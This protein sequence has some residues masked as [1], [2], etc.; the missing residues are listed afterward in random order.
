MNKTGTI[1]EL[2][3]NRATIMTNECRYV[4][5]KRR[6]KM[7]VGQQVVFFES[8]LIKPRM[9]VFK[10]AGIAVSIAVGFLLIFLSYF[11]LIENRNIY[12]FVN[13]DI[14]PSVEIAIDQGK[15]VLWAKP[16]NEDGK[17]LLSSLKL[18]GESLE[19]A[20]KDILEQ[21]KKNGVIKV[22]NGKYIL[23]SASLNPENAQNKT[24]K[25]E[26]EAKLDSY[27]NSFKDASEEELIW[28]VIHTTPEDRKQA[29]N[30][31]ISSGKYYIY[32]KLIENSRGLS[33]EEVRRSS[34]SGL[35]DKLKADSGTG[36]F[37]DEMPAANHE[38]RQEPVKEAD[39]KD[40]CE[41]DILSNKQEEALVFTGEAKKDTDST[42][43]FKVNPDYSHP[44]PDRVESTATESTPAPP[45]QTP[46]KL[47]EKFTKENTPQGT[48]EIWKADVQYRVGD[49]VNYEGKEFRC[50][51]AHKS[52][53]DWLTPKV[54]ALWQQQV[55]E[56]AAN[57]WQAGISFKS[58]SLVLYQGIKYKCLQSHTS[59]TGWE[60]PNVP[61]LWEK[62]L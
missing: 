6:P 33:M 36:A 21:S 17:T 46:E 20:I 61:A 54:P 31:Q 25:E 13:V 57:T 60:P 37:M 56:D 10:Y 62:Q 35:L 32:R 38:A 39:H 12:A 22:G 55:P 27:L 47:S 51:Q 24:D 53:A 43:T 11:R 50:I 15:V 45:V 8:D 23:I 5:I 4:Y 1:L 41:E 19:D 34:I 59:I 30:N 29:V 9:A 58:G 40:G 16:I 26:A 14:N 42:I 2:K 18:K 3:R 52:Q 7:F 44:T 28:A 49:V 48:S